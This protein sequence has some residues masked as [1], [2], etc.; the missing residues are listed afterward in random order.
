MRG[1]SRPSPR[2]ASSHGAHA[3][4]LS[5]YLVTDSAL[6]GGIDRVPSVVAAAVRGG[7]GTVQ[8]REKT[9][10]DDDVAELVRAC[11]EAIRGAVGAERA[12]RIAVFVDDRPQVAAR[13]RCHLHV[14]QTDM[15]VR[16]ARTLLGEDLMIGLSA[17]DPAQVRAAV[18]AGDADLL[19]IG[20][21]RA[22]ATKTDAAAPLGIQGLAACLREIPKATA[23]RGRLPATVAIGGIDVENAA[24]VAATGVGGICVVSAIARAE[25]PEAAARALRAALERG[26]QNRVHE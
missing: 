11:R 3:V 25:D 24:E 15:P 1:A 12:E 26:R 19:G 20:P 6:S 4:D 5:L 2:G 23:G 9:A 17:S 10:S 16:E 13:L 21:V 7:A 22:T 18:E 14:G 8:V